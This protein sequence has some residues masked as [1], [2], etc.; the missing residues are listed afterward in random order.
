MRE[1]RVRGLLIYCGD[2]HCSHSIALSADRWP[3]DVRLSDLEPRF[4]CQAYGQRGADIRPDF[5]WNKQPLAMMGYRT[6]V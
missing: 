3:E 6:L 4:V 5:N 1:S 2:Y